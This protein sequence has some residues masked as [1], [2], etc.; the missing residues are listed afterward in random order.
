[1][2]TVKMQK[3]IGTVAGKLQVSENQVDS[4]LL[5]VRILFD[6]FCQK[7]HADLHEHLTD[8]SIL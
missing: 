1:M 3:N 2:T 4:I 5:K 8:R 7:V 6:V